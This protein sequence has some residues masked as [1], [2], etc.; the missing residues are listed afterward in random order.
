[1]AFEEEDGSDNVGPRKPPQISRKKAINLALKL[2]TKIFVTFVFVPMELWFV[3]HAFTDINVNGHWQSDQPLHFLVLVLMPFLSQLGASYIIVSYWMDEEG[4]TVLRLRIFFAACP[5]WIFFTVLLMGQSTVFNSLSC[6][7]E[8]YIQ[9]VAYLQMNMWQT[10]TV[11]TAYR[12]IVTGKPRLR[13]FNRILV[14]IV[15]WGFPFIWTTILNI[16]F[17]DAWHEDLFDSELRGIGWCGIK[18]ERRI[19]KALFINTPQFI[20]VSAYAQFYFYIHQIIDPDI[21]EDFE[22][23]AKISTSKNAKLANLDTMRK[24]AYMSE[25]ALSLRL[26]MSAYMSSFLTNTLI[27]LIGDNL[28]EPGS[29]SDGYLLFQSGVVTCQGFLTAIIYARTANKSIAQAYS[30]T[31]QDLM[32]MF[33]EEWALKLKLAQERRRE[34]KGKTLR[35]SHSASAR[36]AG[37]STVAQTIQRFLMIFYQSFLLFPVSVWVWVPM[38][39]I[40][41]NTD[42]KSYIFIGLCVWGVATVFPIY[43]FSLVNSDSD[44]TGSQYVAPVGSDPVMMSNI[45]HL[46]VLFVFGITGEYTDLSPLYDQRATSNSIWLFLYVCFFRSTVIVHQSIHPQ[47]SHDRRCGPPEGSRRIHGPRLPHEFMPQYDD[48][49]HI[50]SRVL[51]NFW[52]SLDLYSHGATVCRTIQP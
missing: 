17:E 44:T 33:S 45:A 49:L 29:T 47:P 6:S 7:A 19:L 50:V 18:S 9:Q 22:S 32:G 26:Q 31:F 21:E 39:F 24:A 5:M 23:T 14:H 38:V 2:C 16:F 48:F 46:Y 3:F 35:E 51:P 43:A 8:G 12:F 15:C 1:M 25:T 36:G 10:M 13:G 52:S 4:W 28:F 42:N 20:L 40:A 34:M 30:D 41:E 11:F 37:S 27:T